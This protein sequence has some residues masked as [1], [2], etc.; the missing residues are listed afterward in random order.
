MSELAPVPGAFS[1]VG[2]SS[3]F[4]PAPAATAG[5]AE[6]PA[7]P[8]A[9]ATAQ[10]AFSTRSLLFQAT[11][12]SATLRVAAAPG[13]REALKRWV[14]RRERWLNVNQ[15]SE[16]RFHNV[17]SI[18]SNARL[19]CRAGSSG[20]GRCWQ[21]RHRRK[22]TRILRAYSAPGSQRCSSASVQPQDIAFFF[23]AIHAR[24][25]QLGTFITNA[26]F[27]DEGIR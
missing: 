16:E 14:F 20:R 2:A 22:R 25:G 26:P 6:V 12:P 18:C 7:G 15:V 17:V 19:H 10:S 24:G 4:R 1:G 23:L 3:W 21:S 13:A 5:P 8:V 27:G 9:E 11:E